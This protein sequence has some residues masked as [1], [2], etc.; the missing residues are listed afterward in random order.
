MIFRLEHAEVISY[1]Y[2]VNQI[3][4]SVS[5]LFAK[6]KKKKTIRKDRSLF[7]CISSRSVVKKIAHCCFSI[8]K[9]KT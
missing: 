2:V 1:V 8:D 6:K 3:F 7:L 5:D 4:E 9:M